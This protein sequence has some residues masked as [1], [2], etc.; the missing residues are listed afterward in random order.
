MIV[1]ARPADRPGRQLGERQVDDRPA[2]RRAVPA[3]ERRDPLRRQAASTE[4]P[5]E[6]FVNS[7]ALVDA[8]DLPV[9]GDGARQPDPLGRADPDGPPGPG[10]AGRGDPPRPAARGGA[11]TARPSPSRRGTSPAA[12]G[13]GCRSP[14]PLVRDPSLLI[15]DEATSALDPRTE[16]I[17]DDNLRRRGCTCL[18]IAHRLTHDPGLRRDHRPRRRARRPARARTTS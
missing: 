9:R 14:G 16:R 7:V 8:R 12:S 4:I 17:V 18:I 13:S 1:A 2:D 3:L 6:V 15:L 10:R 5:R 11:A